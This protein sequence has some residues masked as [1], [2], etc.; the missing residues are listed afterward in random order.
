MVAVIRQG[1]KLVSGKGELTMYDDMLGKCTRLL[2]KIPDEA[3]GTVFDLLEKLAGKNREAWLEATKRH[4]RE[5][6]CYRLNG[7]PV[8]ATISTS[9]Y[10]TSTHRMVIQKRT[11]AEAIAAGKYDGYMSHG[12]TSERFSESKETFGEKEVYLFHLNRNIAHKDA[13]TK[14]DTAGYRPATFMDL[15]ALGEN[16]PDLQRQF[17]IVALGSSA[18]WNGASYVPVLLGT[19]NDRRLVLN[20]EGGYGWSSDCR[21]LVVNK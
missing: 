3:S 12:I 2:A 15:L 6:P 11:L 21:F 19:S 17:P 18:E 13:I 16:Q 10:I 20:R 14:I 8:S 4:L 5:V 9:R 7:V 1:H